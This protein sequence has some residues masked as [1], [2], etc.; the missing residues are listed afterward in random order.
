MGVYSA[1]IVG[2][3]AALLRGETNDVRSLASHLDTADAETVLD[4]VM[5]GAELVAERLF[6]I[7][8]LLELAI[9]DLVAMVSGGDGDGITSTV[10]QMGCAIAKLDLGSCQRIAERTR[11][12]PPALREAVVCAAALLEHL[13]SWE[14]EIRKKDAG[15]LVQRCC[16]LVAGES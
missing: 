11:A 4:G 13:F 10:W 16:L 2:C 6:A 8:Q 5:D 9:H 7:S 15:E 1:S 12:T 3:T 14:A